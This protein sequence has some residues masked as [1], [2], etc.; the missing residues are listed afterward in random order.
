MSNKGKNF[1]MGE[2]TDISSTIGVIIFVI[3]VFL[4]FIINLKVI[5]IV[6]VKLPR[7]RLRTANILVAHLSLISICFA[8]VSI[9]NV[10][11]VVHFIN[12]TGSG[13][14]KLIGYSKGE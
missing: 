9:F 1:K 8:L 4:G 3:I 2:E 5:Y 6:V 12:F 11:D 10:S 14:C 13:M 7:K